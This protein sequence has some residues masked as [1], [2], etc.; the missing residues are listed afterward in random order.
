MS[1]NPRGRRESGGV[2]AFTWSALTVALHYGAGWDQ[3]QALAV[4]AAGAFLAGLADAVIRASWPL[5]VPDALAPWAGNLRAEGWRTAR[6]HPWWHCRCG[7]PHAHMITPEGQGVLLSARDLG[8]QEPRDLA[9]LWGSGWRFEHP[10]LAG[11]QVGG[12]H[13]HLVKPG[14]GYLVIR[15]APGKTGQ[16]KEVITCSMLRTTTA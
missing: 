15:L 3:W 8:E 7:D 16:G 9:E 14:E 10:H 2:A 1:R 6:V 11:C 13:V 4:A 12:D 5:R